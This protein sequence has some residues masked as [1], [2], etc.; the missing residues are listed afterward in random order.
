MYNVM[1]Y[2]DVTHADFKTKRSVNPL[3]PEYTVRDEDGKVC[4][5]GSVAGSKPNVLPP[6]R[7]N[8]E[9]VNTSLKTTDIHGCAIGTKGLGNFH[10]RERRAFKDT[11]KT[12]DIEKCHSGSLKKSPPTLRATHPLDPEYQMPGRKEL[13]NINDSFG[14]RN[15][16]QQAILDRHNAKGSTLQKTAEASLGI[17]AAKH[18]ASDV[19]K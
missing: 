2:R 10:T 7:Q 13:T 3:Q 12:E 15:P 18:Q 16:V 14:K 19:P 6:P 1:N 4:E 11:N 8:Q 5:I 9:F 17:A